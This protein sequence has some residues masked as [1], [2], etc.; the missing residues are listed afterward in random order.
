MWQWLSFKLKK[1]LG[2][3][4]K[5]NCGVFIHSDVIGTG[6]TIK[7]HDVVYKIIEVRYSYWSKKK[8]VLFQSK[9]FDLSHK[10]TKVNQQQNI[11]EL[12]HT[13]KCRSYYPYWGR[14]K[15]GWSK[16]FI[17]WWIIWQWKWNNWAGRMGDWWKCNKWEGMI[18]R[19]IDYITSM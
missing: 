15:W 18:S 7:Y 11:I 10:G 13:K 9:W 14:H 12:K 19:M 17:W 8:I 3:R 16:W 6:Q 1:F 4:K 5:N 2:I